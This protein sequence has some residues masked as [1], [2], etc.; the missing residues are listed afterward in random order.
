MKYQNIERNKLDYILTDLLP[1][2]LSELFSLNSFYNYL[3]NNQKLLDAIVS[4][5]RAEI[6]KNEKILFENGW[7]TAPLKFNILKGNDGQREISLMNPVSMINVYLFLECYQKEILI[8]LKENSVFSLRYHCKNNDLHYKK[9]IKRISEYYQSTAKKI[10]KGVLQQTGAFFKIRQ[11]NSVSS[12]SSSRKW[13]QLNFK[14]N[15]FARMDYKSCFDSIYTHAYKWISQRNVVD[16]KDAHNSNLYVVI[17]R[18]LE[19]INSKSSNG[20][21]VGPEFSRMIVELLLQQIDM[22]VLRILSGRGLTKNKDYNIFR[23]VDDIFIFANN[24][25]DIDTII[26]IITAAAQ[27][28]LLRPNDLKLLKTTTPFILS[29]WLSRTRDLSEKISSL[30]YNTSEIKAL[31]ENER[32]LIKGGY[33]SVEKIKNDFNAIICDFPNEKRTI[34]SYVL[35]TLL[36]NISKKKDGLKLLKSGSENKA[37]QILEFALYMY[38]FCPCFE[39]TQRIISM[40][41]YF[42]DE[43]DFLGND[44]HHSKLQVLLKKYM[45]ILLRGNLNDLCNLILLFKEYKII[46]PPDYENKIFSKIKELNNPLLLANYLLYSQYYKPYYDTVIKEVEGII[47][48]KINHITKGEEMLQ[49]EFWYILIFNNCPFL[50]SDL[51]NQM[52][53]VVDGI[54]Y[55]LPTYP[56]QKVINLV[57]EFLDSR[58]NNLFFTWGVHKFST[59]KQIAFRTYQRSLFREYKNKN[60]LLLYG[61][62]D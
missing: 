13:Q 21:L 32:C 51:K 26:S 12:F 19:N 7:A 38:A 15:N 23:Y 3:L 6:S 22:D 50:S 44:S 20:V 59:S 35:S 37:F 55:P 8:L 16:S 10:N 60:S 27:K 14:Y 36:N 2:E 11:F 62:L 42:D 54:K 45:F 39:H 53:A 52:K 58:E 24:A 46:M 56:S 34:V 29:S 9:R 28:Y 57:L 30:F 41:V 4:D 5:L 43:L 25:D 48:K 31:S 40:I 49:V 1:V 33:L 61:S 18:I 47:N 17:D